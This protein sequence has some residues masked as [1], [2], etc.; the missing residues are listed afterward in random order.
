MTSGGADLLHQV[1]L[2]DVLRGHVR[3]RGDGLGA[4]CG[5]HRLTYAELD[6]RVNQLA[7]AL[8]AAG[9]GK[10][11]RILW[12]AQN[13]HRL[14]ESLL[15]AA[16]LGAVFCPANWRQSSAE[17]AFVLRDAQPAVVLWQEEEIGEALRGQGPRPKGLALA[18]GRC[19]SS[20]TG[21][22]RT[23]TSRSWPGGGG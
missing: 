22:A 14:L 7:N 4:V 15:A 10:G 23:A 20:T 17:F 16:K 21:A 2:A 3:H 13:C 1:T 11:D 5:E 12:L 8:A 9:V 19:G 18:P 6:N